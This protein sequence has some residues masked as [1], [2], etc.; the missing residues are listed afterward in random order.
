MASSI[1]V[2]TGVARALRN[3]LVIEMIVTQAAIET[4]D[5]MIDNISKTSGSGKVY[6]TN[7]GLGYH[8]SSAPGDYPTKDSGG[9][10]GGV[11]ITNPEGIDFGTRSPD[12]LIAF[13]ALPS[14]ELEYG[15]SR[16]KSRPFIMRSLNEA[17]STRLDK[18]IGR[19]IKTLE[20][21]PQLFAMLQRTTSGARRARARRRRS[22][23]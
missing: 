3:G 17:M 19:V 15:T 23:P 12:V 1:D 21:S 20:T 11:R 22:A 14:L 9:L 10:A 8:A 5:I 16:M 13:P 7:S 6:K 4:Y 18:I 2:N